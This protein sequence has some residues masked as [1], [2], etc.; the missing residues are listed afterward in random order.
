[1][2][3][4]PLHQDP[5]QPMQEAFGIF[6]VAGSGSVEASELRQVL[7]NLGERFTVNE[8]FT[9]VFVLRESLTTNDGCVLFF[10]SLFLSFYR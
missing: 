3:R 5:K 9:A 6:D 8:G 10:F 4:V 2:S 7:G 1:M